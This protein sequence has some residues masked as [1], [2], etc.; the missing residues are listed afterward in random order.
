MD[1]KI[2]KIFSYNHIVN[3]KNS[4]Q[5][6]INWEIKIC[7]YFKLNKLIFEGVTGNNNTIKILNASDNLITDYCCE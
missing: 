4:I 6:V 7:R 3:F 2:F 1:L 5:K